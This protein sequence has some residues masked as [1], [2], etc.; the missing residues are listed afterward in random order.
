MLKDEHPGLPVTV[1]CQQMG[2]CGNRIS[3]T[4]SEYQ[5]MNIPKGVNDHQT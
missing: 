2:N 3:N 1:E 4:S 5:K